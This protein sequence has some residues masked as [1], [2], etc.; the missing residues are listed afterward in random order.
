[1]PERP[2]SI[3]VIQSFSIK[4]DTFVQFYIA[5]FTAISALSFATAAFFSRS[6]RGLILSTAALSSVIL[7]FTVFALLPVNN[8][9]ER[10]HAQGSLK[11]SSDK[12]PSPVQKRAEEMLVKW[13]NLHR[14][15]EVLG[16]GAWVGGMAALILSL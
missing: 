1:M 11:E 9:L 8:E 16:F 3:F 10:M 7:P 12:E 2:I 5:P 13:G 4:S 15:R 6:H 14:V